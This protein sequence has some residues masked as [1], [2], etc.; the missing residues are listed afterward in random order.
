MPRRLILPAVAFLVAL[1]A[2]AVLL[3]P[4]D[5][6]PED[7]TRAAHAPRVTTPAPPLRIP[8]LPDTDAMAEI[9][10][11]HQAVRLAAQR[12]HGKPLDIALIPARP[13][14]A[15]S[16][17]LLVYRLRML[18]GSRDVLDIRMDAVSGR[19]LELSGA[20]LAGVHRGPAPRGDKKK[21]K[22]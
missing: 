20:D 17:V 8:D 19:V 18:T 2:A 16:G 14:E 22:D 4:G 21:R 6:R 9:L 7:H 10:P 13:A 5:D 3:L 11:M 12:F 1:I 15:A